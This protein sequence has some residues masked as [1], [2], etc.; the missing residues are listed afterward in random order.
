MTDTAPLLPKVRLAEDAKDMPEPLPNSHRVA[1]LTSA[2]RR[3]VAIDQ[4]QNPVKA[5]D[6]AR[7]PESLVTAGSAKIPAPT[8][9]PATKAAALPTFPG[10]W[11]NVL[12]SSLQ[13]LVVLVLATFGTG[14]VG[15]DKHSGRITLGPLCRVNV[16]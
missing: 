16:T 15:L 14:S 7:N 4:T 2:I 12:S 8:V 6:E 3:P 10:W 9:V 1:R 11:L 13:S 5:A